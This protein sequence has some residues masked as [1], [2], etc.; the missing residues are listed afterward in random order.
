MLLETSA[1][2]VFLE[3]EGLDVS[4]KVGLMSRLLQRQSLDVELQLL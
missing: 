1:L 3:K 4:T 2:T